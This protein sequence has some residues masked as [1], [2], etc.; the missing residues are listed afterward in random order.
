MIEFRKFLKTLTDSE[1]SISEK[2]IWFYKAMIRRT[3]GLVGRGEGRGGSVVQVQF[4][5]RCTDQKLMKCIL[6]NKLNAHVFGL[7][8]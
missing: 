2:Q 5:F 8:Y 4:G 1:K 6:Y 3:G 7:Y